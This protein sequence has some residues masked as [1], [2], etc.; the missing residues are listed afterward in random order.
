MNADIVFAWAERYCVSISTEFTDPARLTVEALNEVTDDLIQNL[1]LEVQSPSEIALTC[2]ICTCSFN[3]DW[4][5]SQF[6]MIFWTLGFEGITGRLTL[7]KYLLWRF[8]KYVDENQP[9]QEV[10]DED[11]DLELDFEIVYSDVDDSDR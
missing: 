10:S 2:M 5:S 6:R 8:E 7:F 1:V 3:E 4:I 9:Y 11:A